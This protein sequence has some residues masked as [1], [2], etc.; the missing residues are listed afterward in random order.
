MSNKVRRESRVMVILKSGLSL[1]IKTRL[2]SIAIC[3]DFPEK[4]HAK[5]DSDY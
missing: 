2:L 3:H 4:N 5:L 1:H